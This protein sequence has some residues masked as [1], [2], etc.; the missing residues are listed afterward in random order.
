MSI[1]WYEV[2]ADEVLSVPFILLLRPSS[3][4][5]EIIDPKG[6]QQEGVRGALL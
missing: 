2:W 1:N 5:F 3:N 6:G 4:G